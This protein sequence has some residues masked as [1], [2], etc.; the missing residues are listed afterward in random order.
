M[1]N[2]L[3]PLFLESFAGSVDLA[4]GF[5]TPFFKGESEVL[6]T[7]AYLAKDGASADDGHC[8]S[9]IMSHASANSPSSGI[10]GRL[11]GPVNYSFRGFLSPRTTVQGSFISSANFGSFFRSST[12]R[13]AKETGCL[14]QMAEAKGEHLARIDN[15]KLLMTFEMCRVVALV[16][17]AKVF[18][19]ARRCSDRKGIGG[20]GSLVPGGAMRRTRMIKKFFSVKQNRFI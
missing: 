12:P 3:R 17:T 11:K 6:A 15:V 14:R 1:V 10:P 5:V 4:E 20:G 19:Y 16:G 2:R 18:K 8:R 9:L 13:G 7:S